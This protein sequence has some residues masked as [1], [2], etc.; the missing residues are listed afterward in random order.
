MS[1]AFSNQQNINWQTF[2]ADVKKLTEQ[3]KQQKELRWAICCGDSYFFCIA[4]FAAACAAKKIVLPG[5][6]QPEMLNSLSAEFDAM[7]QDGQLIDYS[8]KKQIQLPISNNESQLKLQPQSQAFLPALDLAKVSITLFTSGSSGLPKPIVK[9]LTLLDN[10]IQQLEKNWGALLTNKKIVST[11]SHQHIYGLLFRLLWPLCAGR[12]FARTNLIYPEQV[13][14]NAQS[15]LVLI[16]SPALLKRIEDVTGF[17]GY[18]AVFSSGG[19]LAYSAVRQS[20]ASLKQLPIEVFGSTETGGIG[21]RQQTRE[22]CVWTFFEGIVAD[23]D[24]HDC[25]TLKSPWIGDDWYQTADQCQ[26]LGQHNGQK[27]F[28]VKGRADKIVK[29]E[30]KR[31]SLIEVEQHLTELPWIY[32]SAVILLETEQRSALGGVLA[33]TEEGINEINRLGKGKFWILLRQQL[34]LWIEPVAIPRYFRVIN[35]IPV[36]TQGK[37]SH[38]ELI[39]LFVE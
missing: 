12:S 23:T 29:I 20:S 7:L 5:N 32:E 24:A 9:R 4:F 35:E 16:S 14:A 27:K 39:K 15:N 30:E 13:V 34:R 8:D 19:S 11:V 38:A 33:L 25:L 3:L 31:I 10:E 36:N 26:L 21:Y 1:V 17:D 18:A 37:R 22:G 28:I 6:H 2:I